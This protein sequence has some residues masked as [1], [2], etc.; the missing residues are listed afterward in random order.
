LKAGGSP[1]RRGKGRGGKRT[2]LGNEDCGGDEVGTRYTG[3]CI[4]QTSRWSEGRELKQEI[5]QG[6]NVEWNGPE[7]RQ[8]SKTISNGLYVLDPLF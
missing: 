7:S 5:C 6:G 4:V 1:P 2:R 8:V 3:C